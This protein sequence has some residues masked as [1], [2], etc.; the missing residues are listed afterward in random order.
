MASKDYP[1]S[2]YLNGWLDLSAERIVNSAAEEEAA[3]AEGYK[4][5]PEFPHPDDFPD[6][7]VTAEPKVAPAPAPK[8]D[9]K[10]PVAPKPP[11]K[12]KA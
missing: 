10:P 7:V 12:T 2:L 9:P 8:P 1:R 11:K 4:T 5:L 3:R 6:G